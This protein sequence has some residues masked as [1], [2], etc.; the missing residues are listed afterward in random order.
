[1]TDLS[2]SDYDLILARDAALRRAEVAE[3]RERIAAEAYTGQQQSYRELETLYQAS[4]ERALRAEEERDADVFNSHIILS[5][6]MSAR[7]DA[8]ALREAL[9][10]LIAGI[11]VHARKDL[12]GYQLI[13]N[14][15]AVFARSTLDFRRSGTHLLAEL[16]AARAI[17][18]TLRRHWDAGGE[19]W[20]SIDRD[21]AAYDAAVKENI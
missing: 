3:Q 16:A 18:A 10:V 19:V 4:Q 21:F 13:T 9:N 5:E 15:A 7:S 2:K 12:D 20:G 14:T 6:A 1:M 17:V 11:K 8:A